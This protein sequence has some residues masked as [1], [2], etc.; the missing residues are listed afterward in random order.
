M[1]FIAYYFHWNMEEIMRL[2]HLSRKRWCREISSINEKVGSSEEKKE[3][4]IFELKP[5]R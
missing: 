4:N 2:E 3:K 5:S 1:S